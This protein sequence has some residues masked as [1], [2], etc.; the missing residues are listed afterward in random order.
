VLP[1]PQVVAFDVDASSLLSIR[2]AIPECRIKI[3]NG[4]TASTI[5][6]PWNV[7]VF[8]LVVLGV[9]GDGGN[10]LGLCRSLAYCNGYCEDFD[11]LTPKVVQADDGQSRSRT[12]NVPLLV[13]MSPS[14]GH[15]VQAFLEAGAHSCLVRPVHFKDVLGMLKRAQAGNK[16]GRHTLNLEGAQREDVWRDAGGE[17]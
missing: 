12:S 4:A 9:V 15:L 3:V 14:Q 13:L 1:L 6:S 16:P 10:S 7:R 2:E 11:P 5:A 8:D 17:G